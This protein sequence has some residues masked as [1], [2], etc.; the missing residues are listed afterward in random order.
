MASMNAAAE[1]GILS[2][3]A[4]GGSVGG[5]RIVG[6]GGHSS[7]DRT[8]P[9]R[10]S[11]SRIDTSPY[12]S[13]RC[14]PGGIG[15]SAGSGGGGGGGYINHLSPPDH[16]RRVHSDSSL[17]HSVGVGG[18]GQVQVGAV[19][20]GS[21]VLGG[22]GLM[23]VANGNVSPLQG[24]SPKLIRRGGLAAVFTYDCMF[25]SLSIVHGGT[26]FNCQF[27]FW[28]NLMFPYGCK[29]AISVG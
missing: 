13:E 24:V 3:S 15:A 16:W 25:D 10:S 19:S 4:G 21:I 26:R 27:I 28:G 2:S 22:G 17:H 8:G 11:K 18:G 14:S 20:P 29:L 5:C 6:G 23:M 7:R 1:G 9:I 12:G